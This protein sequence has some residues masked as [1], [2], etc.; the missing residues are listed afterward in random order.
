MES[1]Q[2]GSATILLEIM[3][4]PIKLPIKPPPIKPEGSTI[5]VYYLSMIKVTSLKSKSRNRLE[6][7]PLYFL[8]KVLYVD[9]FN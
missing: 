4:D 1:Q 9:S 6:F 2:M 8:R 5:G 3:D 7:R